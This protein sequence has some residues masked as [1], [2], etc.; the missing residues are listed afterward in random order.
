M[1]G[2]GKTASDENFPVGSWLIA[3][4]HRP[5][6]QAYYAFART[7][8][9]IADA[10]GLS[11][12]EKL[13]RL[14]ALDA[15]LAHDRPGP[16]VEVALQLR[17]SLLER[18]IPLRHGL[19]LLD[20]FRQDVTQDRYADWAGLMAYCERSAAPVGRFLLDLHGEAR[21]LYPA[22][23]ALCQALQ[24]INHLQDCGEDYR[25]LGRI[26]LP[27]DWL[28]AACVAPSDL[29]G[30]RLSPGLRQ[31]IDRCLDAVESLLARSRHLAPALAHTRLALETGAIQHL[32]E[33]LVRQLRRRDP[34]AGRVARGRSGL[35]AH[36]T[37]GAARTALGRLRR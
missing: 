34:L 24:V 5:H 28:A 3:A 35:V 7:A 16:A 11:A 37:I 4:A 18:A 2:S 12:D 8:D 29:A 1:T 15:A 10:P 13:R 33:D 22:A 20:A 19:D 31:V 14:D 9:D 30:D 21:T 23:D 17:A 26:Y 27:A 25:Q 6:V 36:A 32:A